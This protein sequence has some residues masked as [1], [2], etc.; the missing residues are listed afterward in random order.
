M[1]EKTITKVNNDLFKTAQTDAVYTMVGQ[2][3]RY[4]QLVKNRLRVRI[5]TDSMDGCDISC[6]GLLG[7]IEESRELISMDYGTAQSSS[8]AGT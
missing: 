3:L 1:T 7:I 8:I 6:R 4:W 5:V 2:Q